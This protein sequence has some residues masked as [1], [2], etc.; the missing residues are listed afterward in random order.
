MAANT[1]GDRMAFRDA[2]AWHSLGTVF[3][4]SP[5]ATEALRR[6]RLG[7]DVER[8]PLYI[9]DQEDVASGRFVETEQIAL[10]RHAWDG[11]PGTI[12][13]YATK[14][15]YP[16]QNH[17]LARMLDPLTREWPL[18]TIGALGNGETIFV[19]LDAGTSEVGGDEVKQY[20]FAYN[21]HTGGS[22]FRIMVT[23]VRVV[24]A[25]TCYTGI[26]RATI[27]AAVRH[28]REIVSQAAF[29]VD[30]IAQL[31]SSQ[32]DVIAGLR[33]LTKIKV[34]YAQVKRI[35]ETVYTE[36]DE[37]D[38]LDLLAQ[39]EAGTITLTDAQLLRLDGK[40][41][42]VDAANRSAK[43][44]QVLALEQ[45]E[46]FH[47]SRPEYKWTAW[48]V[49]NAVTATAS[50]RRGGTDQSRVKSSVM[51]GPRSQEMEVAYRELSA[52]AR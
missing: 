45:L 12:L 1:Y 13:G 19:T 8:V 41:A 14:G 31:R 49:Y 3:T 16:L 17:E 46:E 18:E 6:A 15:Y 28:T 50:W 9:R 2:P 29:A 27:T 44:L 21:E 30:L 32:D 11:T 39:A 5:T 22:A 38:D 40:R 25:N 35:I 48:A 4:D 10:Y 20:L 52:L 24:C 7:Y 34:D 47:E 43:K 37:P 23:P 26:K 36:R 33:G 42:A 51:G